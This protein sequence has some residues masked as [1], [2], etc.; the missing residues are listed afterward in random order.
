MSI[1]DIKK[2]SDFAKEKESENVIVKYSNNLVA[3]EFEI[4]DMKI[5]A[6]SLLIQ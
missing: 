1:I 3:F 6:T 4:N 2:I 5:L